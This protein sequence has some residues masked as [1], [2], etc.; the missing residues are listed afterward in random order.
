M[1]SIRP[2]IFSLLFTLLFVESRAQAPE[3]ELCKIMETEGIKGK[4][5]FNLKSVPQT[6]LYDV[7]YYRLDLNIFN[8]TQRY[9]SGKVTSYFTALD[10]GMNQIVFDL[11]QQLIVDSV[12]YL[13][14]TVPFNRS[15]NNAVSIQLPNGLQKNQLDS[16]TIFYQGTPALSGLGSFSIGQNSNADSVLWTLSEPYGA[17]D[18]WPCKNSLTDKADSVEIIVSSS[19]NYKTA[20]IGLLKNIDTIASTVRYHWKTTYPIAT[21]LVAIAISDYQVFEEH[22]PL[23]NDSLLMQ[24]FLFQN[25]SLALS[26]NG[27]AEFLQFFDSL[28]GE[29]PFIKEKYGHASFPP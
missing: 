8:P 2:F 21:Y 28:F 6:A 18:W 4:Q 17:S 15:I 7:K 16:L 10:S 5:R 26:N 20:S 29:Y 22:L 1:Q 12:H 25:E 3:F 23:G 19:I 27:I 24:H 13:N 11:N 9:I 14:D